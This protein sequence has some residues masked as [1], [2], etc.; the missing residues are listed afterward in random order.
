MEAERALVAVSAAAGAELAVWH[1]GAALRTGHQ[2][3]TTSRP[4]A[5]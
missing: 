3:N 1:L 4:A 5:G 2:P